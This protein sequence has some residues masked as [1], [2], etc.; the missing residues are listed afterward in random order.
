MKEHPKLFTYE[1]QEREL[2]LVASSRA[3]LY[4]LRL[5]CINRELCVI[6]SSSDLDS[7]RL[8][9]NHIARTN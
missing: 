4:C 5:A 3:S 7:K 2:A 6:A 8:T 1:L 9:S